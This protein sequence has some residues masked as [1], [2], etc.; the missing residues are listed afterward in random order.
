MPPSS[1]CI[2]PQKHTSVLCVFE[3]GGFHCLPFEV[4]LMCSYLALLSV[5]GTCIGLWYLIGLGC[6]HQIGANGVKWRCATKPCSIEMLILYSDHISYKLLSSTLSIILITMIWII[7]HIAQNLVQV[8]HIKSLIVILW[9]VW[10][11]ATI[12]CLHSKPHYGLHL[13]LDMCEEMPPRD[14]STFSVYTYTVCR[15]EESESEE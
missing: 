8:L 15:V 12:E 11:G 4:L 14:Y 6:G 10:V 13:W 3:D 7:L 9:N 5:K 1:N 2:Q